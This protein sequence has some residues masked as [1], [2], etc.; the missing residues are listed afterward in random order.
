[1]KLSRRT[2]V[3]L[4]GVLAVAAVA[5]WFLFLR[6]PRIPPVYQ[7]TVVKTL[8]H[9]TQAFTEGLFFKDGPALRKYRRGRHFGRAQ[10]AARYRRNRRRSAAVAALFR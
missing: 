5:I 1:M 7:V 2:L 9:D 8:P 4:V 6:G 3:I 10:D